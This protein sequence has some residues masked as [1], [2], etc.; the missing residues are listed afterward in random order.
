MI[1]G[2]E[3]ETPELTN[4][5]PD[6]ASYHKIEAPKIFVVSTDKLAVSPTQTVTSFATKD[7]KRTGVTSD[8]PT[9][10]AVAPFGSNKPS[11]KVPVI[12]PLAPPPTFIVGP[13]EEVLT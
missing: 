9:P 4:T 8:S 1:P 6:G 13:T 7:G 10:P 3:K 11:K 12:I 5:P 2:I